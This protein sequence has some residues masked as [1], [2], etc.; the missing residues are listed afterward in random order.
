MFHFFFIFCLSYKRERV[1]ASYRVCLNKIV[2]N[3]QK[4][5][6]YT[7]HWRRRIEFYFLNSIFNH[8]KILIE[9][10]H[11]V[12]TNGSHTN[13]SISISVFEPVAVGIDLYIFLSRNT[14]HLLH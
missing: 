4:K 10:D 7:E 14:K 12:V 9:N 2:I 1:Y 13:Y 5:T 6:K 8:L 11:A 3:L